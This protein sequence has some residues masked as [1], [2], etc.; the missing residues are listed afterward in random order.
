MK[1]CYIFNLHN[2]RSIDNASNKIKKKEERKK[3]GR[4]ENKNKKG[5][6]KKMSVKHVI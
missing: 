3:K 5:R 4:K 6:K 2:G 1:E